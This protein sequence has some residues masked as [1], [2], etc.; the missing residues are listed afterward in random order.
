MRIEGLGD[1]ALQF[2]AMLID[3]FGVIHDGQKLY[4]GAA[5]AMAQLHA[6]GIPV[7]IMTNSAKRAQASI[8]RTVRLGIPR[9]H[10]LDCVS[11]GEVAYQS[12]TAKTAFVVGKRGENYGFDQIQIVDNPRN[13]EVMLIL[14]SNAPDTSLSDYEDLFRNIHLPAICCNPDLLMITPQGLQPAPGAIAGVYEK[15]GRK[16]TYIGK[17]HAAIYEFALERLNHPRRV[18]CIGDSAE[19]DVAGG[20]AAGLATLLVLQGVSAGVDE[21][22]ID[23]RPDYVAASFKW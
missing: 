14:G 11:S 17:P 5:Q 7:M 6:L 15:L 4:P 10:F 18:L 22:R 12:F 19:H 8:T 21:S 13:A 23:P 3:Q 2:D 9:E 1:I 16:V 20:R